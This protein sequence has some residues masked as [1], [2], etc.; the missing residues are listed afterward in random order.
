MKPEG[1]PAVPSMPV[2]GVI[3][4]DKPLGMSFERGAASSAQTVRAWSKAGHT[5]T[6]DPLATG[7]LPM[8]LGE[9]TKFAAGLLD[10]DKTYEA[11]IRLGVA[12]TTGDAEGEPVI[13]RRVADCP[14]RAARDPGEFTGQIDQLPPM[15]S[16][17]KHQG[18][19]LYSYARAGEE[20]ERQDLDESPY[21]GSNYSRLAARVQDQS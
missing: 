12:T 7:L 21:D 4:L 8:C 13:S 1:L 6:L 3:L 20:V 11:T 19:P 9:A 16:A 15:L 2:D 18:R 10:A 14:E 5:G 17:L